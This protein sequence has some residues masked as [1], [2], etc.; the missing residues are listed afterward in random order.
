MI[1][2]FSVSH[3]ILKFVHTVLSKAKAMSRFPYPRGIMQQVAN[4]LYY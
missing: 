2:L 1:K 4:Y 3:V